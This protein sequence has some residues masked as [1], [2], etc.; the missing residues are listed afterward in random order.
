MPVWGVIVATWL[1][2]EPF[3]RRRALGAALG[4]AGLLLLLG[5]EVQAVGR[6]PLG[7]ML[8]VGAAVSWAL[9][10][11]MMKRW[12][13]SLPASSFTAWQMLISAAPII[14][15]ALVFE[16]G[17]F[18][19]F[20]LS[21]WPMLGIFYNVFVAFNFCY[22]AWTKIALVAPVGVS[23]LAIMMTPVVGV[24]SGMLLLGETPHWQDYAALV[25]VVASLAT[26]LLPP[27]R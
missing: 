7:A 20:A 19:P 14:V 11:I 22:W 12:P 10:T 13:V 21:L 15:F 3:T 2:K 9:S 25:L 18:N 6:S 5:E 17:T 26:V 4:G 1:L 24:F 23:S 8:M 27:R 16:T